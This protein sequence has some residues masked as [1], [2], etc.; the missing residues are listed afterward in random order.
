V[1][2]EIEHI[3]IRAPLPLAK[4]LVEVGLAASN[5]EGRRLIEQGA[6]SIDEARA[7]DPFVELPTRSDPYLFKVGKRRFARVQVGSS[8]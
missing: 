1:P 5:A 8:S 7:A 6:V 4:L 2:E 3:A